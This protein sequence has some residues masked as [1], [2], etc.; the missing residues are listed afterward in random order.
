MKTI[1]IDDAL[2][3][4]IASHTLAIGEDASAILR[5]L[6]NLDNESTHMVTSAMPSALP[7]KTNL[8][9]S[10]LQ[11]SAFLSERK[12]VNRF[13]FILARLY[14]TNAALFSVASASLHG[15]K[16]RY[17]AKDEETLLKTG[18]NTKPRQIESTPYWVIT[19][20]NSARKV[21]ILETIMRNMDITIENRKMIIDQFVA[22]KVA[23]HRGEK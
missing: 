21:Y 9:D 17:L 22:N 20:T 7:N 13:L 16:R 15:S 5:R 8:L 4:Y 14:H 10:L 1:E 19:N 12:I 18:N 2:Y 23:D 11:D 3:Q 6:L